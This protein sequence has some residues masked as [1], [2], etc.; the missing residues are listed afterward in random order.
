MHELQASERPDSWGRALSLSSGFHMHNNLNGSPGEG[1]PVCAGHYR[2]AGLQSPI[3]SSLKCFHSINWD[4]SSQMTS[5]LCEDVQAG[6]RLPHHTEGSRSYGDT[7]LFVYLFLPEDEGRILK[8]STCRY[9]GSWV[10]VIL[11]TGVGARR[12]LRIKYLPCNQ[13]RG[14]EMIRHDGVCLKSLYWECWDKG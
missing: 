12:W 4:K 14:P 5:S 6:H 10:A 13:P 2:S 1:T 11:K 9:R 3:L 8:Q 7:C